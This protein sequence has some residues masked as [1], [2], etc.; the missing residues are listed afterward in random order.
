V[1]RN[2]R[3]LRLVTCRDS[4]A[5][6]PLRAGVPITGAPFRPGEL[7]VVSWIPLDLSTKSLVAE[8]IKTSELPVE[9][10]VRIAVEASRL[11]DE[12]ASASNL[13]TQH[14][15]EVLDLAADEELSRPPTEIATGHALRRYAA[16]L[17]C[18][19]RRETPG[20]DLALRLPE[21]MCGAWS[22]A[23]VVA[24][25][26]LPDWVATRLREAP[27]QSVSWEAAAASAYQSLGEWAYACFLRS[28]A[29]ASA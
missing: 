3:R 24:H 10:W 26:T 25:L 17:K 21:E 9:L 1:C 13:S 20:D 4:S 5:H 27:R 8:G 12:I 16:E 19:H 23:S 18:S 15:V 2:G 29:N 7:P 14:V 11:T 22:A 28:C 6:L